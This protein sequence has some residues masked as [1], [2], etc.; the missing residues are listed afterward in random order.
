MQFYHIYPL[1][2]CGVW[3]EIK[4]QN[5]TTCFED[6]SRNIEEMKEIG[7]DHVLIGP[8]FHS[9][10]HGYDTTHYFRVDPRLGDNED[11]R[12]YVNQ[13]HG[14]QIKV[15]V[16]TVFNHVGRE[17][18]QFKDVQRHRENSAYRHWFRGLNFGKNNPYND[19][20][21]YETW[22]GH[23]ELVKL[24]LTQKD[25][26][27]YL[28]SVVEFW[29]ETF[30]IDGLRLDA[31]D[32]MDIGF[33]HRLK[34]YCKAKRPDFWIVGEVVHGDYNKWLKEAGIDSV[35]NYEA[36]KGLFSSLNDAN[37]FEIGYALNRQSGA[38]GVYKGANLY[39]FVDNHDV[40]RVASRL[41]NPADLYPLYLMLFTMPGTPSIYY[42]SEY[43]CSG[44]KQ[45]NSDANLR[46]YFKKRQDIQ[47]PDGLD[48]KSAI[49]RFSD[50]RNQ[51]TS[52]KTG[53]YEQVHLSHEQIVY[54]RQNGQ[55]TS[56]VAI[57]SSQKCAGV[58]LKGPAGVYEDVLNGHKSVH[59][60]GLVEIPSKWGMILRKI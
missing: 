24:D 59:L 50:V 4:R 28:L 33:M 14:Q 40:N 31:A 9:L 52:L 46:P 3:P 35:T 42:L 17:F 20:F 49:R 12:N 25:V 47:R 13:C 26:Q 51:L 27:D 34:G 41:N 23:Y 37:Y 36:Y 55:E 1:G 54:S 19:G 8:L 10:T 53:G 56:L 5:D 45:N 29:I 58:Y 44:E 6:L 2:Y 43:G 30:D 15:I 18:E 38:N 11:F 48:L 21:D 16:D 57:N 60:P 39:N 32:V 7:T 22:D